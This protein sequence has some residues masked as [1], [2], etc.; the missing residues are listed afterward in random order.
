MASG[1]SIVQTGIGSVG[2]VPYH[3]GASMTNTAK[4]IVAD[5]SS[6]VKNLFAGYGIALPRTADAQYKYTMTGSKH[7]TTI[8]APGQSFS[9]SQLL[10]GDLVFMGGWNDPSNPPG[11]AGIQHVT[12][13]A[14]GNN[15][16]EEG[17]TSQNVN[18][19]SIANFKGKVIAV[20]RVN[21]VTQGTATPTNT[22]KTS[23]SSGTT[24]SSGDNL[25]QNQV[26]ANL[27]PLTLLNTMFGGAADATGIPSAIGAVGNTFS[28]VMLFLTIVLIG[29]AL[30]VVG[31]MMTT[32][33]SGGDVVKTAATIGA[34][35]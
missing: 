13:Y 16:V 25:L 19:T 14:G 33:T 2:K 21:G 26:V 17:G 23:S 24:S 8:V 34:V 30:L 20:T 10:P 18:V 4:G 27:N 28:T 9:T 6:F 3:L 31:A 11:Y 12:V 29:I 35:A 7:G 15:V 22:S 5:C 32:H 1:T